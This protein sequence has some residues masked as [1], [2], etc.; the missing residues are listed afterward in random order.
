MLRRHHDCR[1]SATALPVTWCSE[2]GHVAR[3]KTTEG[4]A[5]WQPGGAKED[6]RFREGN[7][8]LRLAYEEE[9]LSPAIPGAASRSS[10]ATY[11]AY[12]TEQSH[13]Q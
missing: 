4:Q 5:L 12:Q 7:R 1:T 11:R 3:T 2:A 13:A 10:E 8:H 6:S 9:E